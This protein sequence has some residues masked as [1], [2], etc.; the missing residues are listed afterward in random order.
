M[1]ERR[2]YQSYLLRIWQVGPEPCDWR[3]M[4]ESASTGERH[5]FAT[6]DDLC[7]WIQARAGSSTRHPAPFVKKEME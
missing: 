4:L 1:A 7:D 2:H 5:G 3:A 6:L